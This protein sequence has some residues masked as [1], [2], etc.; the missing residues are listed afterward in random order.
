MKF[1]IWSDL[2]TEWYDSLINF[3]LIRNVASENLILAG[4]IGCPATALEQY[5]YF[6]S[7]CSRKFKN[8]F[9]LC[10]NHEAYGTSLYN[11]KELIKNTIKEFPNIHFMDKTRYDFPNTNVSMLGCVLWSKI[12]DHQQG[13]IKNGLND[14]Y[15]IENFTL[16]DYHN[17]HITDLT[18]L[19]KSILEIQENE[20]NRQIIVVTHHAPILE[21]TSHPQFDNSPITSAFASDLSYLVKSPVVAFIFGHSHYSSNQVINGV[22]IIS[23]QLGYPGEQAMTGSSID[24]VVLLEI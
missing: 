2:H 12:Q 5:R 13:R 7:D 18:W 9:L 17:E 19:E 8:I 24:K 15:R 3:P 6:L 1:Q 10:G 23:N 4:D 20:P 14:F 22:R 11:A 16:K 21:G